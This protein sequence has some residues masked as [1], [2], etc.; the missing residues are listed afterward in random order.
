M[1]LK[2]EDVQM[3]RVKSKATSQVTFDADYNV[4]D[5]K[6]DIARM[7]QNKGDV[8]IDEVRLNDGHAFLKGNLNVDLLYVGE[9][10]G[11]I[12]SLSAKL[13][14]EET[15]NLE[16]IV[17][18]DKMCLKWEIEDL[19]VHMIH[20]RKLN[21]KAIV[22]FFA[23]VDELA[24]VRLPVS[25]E[26]EGISVRKK[27]V[28]LMSLIV[29][30]KDTLRLKEEISLASN[31]PNIA[32]LLWH[33][34]E[35]RGLELRPEENVIK[36]KGELF[37]FALYLGEDDSN[38]PLQWLEYSIPFHGEAECS[39]CTPEMITN[40]DT[41][42]IH[43]GLEIKPDADGEER[44]L[45]ADVVL[46]L[47]MKLYR[48]EEHD[49]ILDVYTPLKECIPHGKEEF[50]ESLLIKNYSKCR[51]TDRIEVKETQGKILQICHSQGK[52]KL[53]KM[54][55]VENGILVEG[56]VHLK[57][58][59]IVG[60]DNMPFYSM[61]AMIPFTHVVEARG[62][63]E[64]CTFYLKTDMEQLS[65][66]M[67]DSNEIE[68]KAVLSLNALVMKCEAEMIIE[69]IETQPLDMKKIQAMPGVTVY[70]S[71]PEDTLWDIAKRF[72]T[73]VEEICKWNDMENEELK[74]C[75][76]LLL[77][78]KVEY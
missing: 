47:N 40:I 15:L 31:K 71:K 45:A 33:T 34:I 26:E 36:A 8:T 57:V 75:Q 2:K 13:P 19:S 69:K 53:D 49:L 44:I 51:V 70:M 76:P 78:K 24:G 46:E 5:V 59:Y 52:I 38:Q 64:E 29:N 58:L 60:N 55:I 67:V 39:G 48:E 1:E 28:N 23:V 77:V 10:E 22:T 56:I 66:T 74:P 27:K 41:A 20:S 9:E 62:I 18:G 11:K 12:Y 63:T 3:L 14:M 42:V 4:P 73:T 65:T 16:G 6:P 72:Y 30:K 61:D 68:V 50:L 35:V 17:S 25:L 32:E 37:V 54:Q 21:I 7:I 43:Q